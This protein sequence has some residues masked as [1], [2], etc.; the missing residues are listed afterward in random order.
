MKVE[1]GPRQSVISLRVTPEVRR[2]IEQLA[3]VL[4]IRR[5]KRHTITDVME[6]SIRMLARK[7]KVT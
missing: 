1:H 5:G 4:T 7:E 2:M 6:E 3:A